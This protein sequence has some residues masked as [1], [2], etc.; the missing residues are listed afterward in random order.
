MNFKRKIRFQLLAYEKFIA[1]M[2]TTNLYAL[3][4]IIRFVLLYI[5]A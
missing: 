2:K 4:N 1:Y 5:N 3:Y